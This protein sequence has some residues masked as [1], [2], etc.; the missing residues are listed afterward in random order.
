MSTNGQGNGHGEPKI[1]KDAAARP[2]PK[3]FYKVAAAAVT[4]DGLWRLELDGR[5]A[6]TPGKRGLAVAGEA[7]GRAIADEWQAQGATIDPASMPLTR[8]V[9]SAIDGVTGREAEVAA[10]IANYATSDL[11]CYRAERPDELVARQAAAWDPVLQW[12]RDRHG[13]D[14]RLQTGIMPIAQPANIAE[15]VLAALAESG[16]FQLAALHVMTTLMGSA[17]LPLAV[18]DGHLTPDAAWTAAHVDED[19]QITHWGEDA[20]ARARRES[21]WR[22]MAAAARLLALIDR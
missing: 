9:N 3:R 1:G 13:L 12:A 11:L 19:W 18:A 8:L 14:L 15:R 17:L 22:D 21:R 6:R 7:L 10:D 4:S 16:T 5:P 2:L 20:E